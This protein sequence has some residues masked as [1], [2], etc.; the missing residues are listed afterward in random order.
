MLGNSSSGI[1][2]VPS[3]RAATINIG[4]RQFGRIQAKS[5]INSNAKKN[6]IIRSINKVY[7]KYFQKNLK[8]IQSPYGKGG[9]A[10]KTIKILEKIKSVEIK[11]R[12]FDLKK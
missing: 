8:N 3:F 7:S 6:D 11:K 4:D 12:F 10:K 2:E 5:I 9:A 1:L